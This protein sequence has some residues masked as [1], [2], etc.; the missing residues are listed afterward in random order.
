MLSEEVC[1]TSGEK[2]SL[3]HLTCWLLINVLL[4]DWFMICTRTLLCSFL[5]MCLRLRSSLRECDRC[6]SS[7]A[8][9]E[10][11]DLCC[12]QQ[13]ARR[14]HLPVSSGKHRILKLDC[15]PHLWLQTH[16]F[17]WSVVGYG[18]SAYLH[19][20]PWTLCSL[21]FNLSILQFICLAG[22][23]R[24]SR[25]CRRLMLLPVVTL[26]QLCCWGSIAGFS[27]KASIKF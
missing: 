24:G 22:K 26:K 1:F 11:R 15:L 3:E 6:V 19:L 17:H 18:S 10:R 14:V 7:E 9:S 12:C 5:P 25:Y 13:Y 27:V 8:V 20:C 21:S 16:Q 2:V 23:L 4:C